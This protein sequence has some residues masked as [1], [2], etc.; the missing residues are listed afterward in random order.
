MKGNDLIELARKKESEKEYDEAINLFKE[1]FEK[2]PKN[3][4]LQIELGNVFALCN[5][6]EEAAG[7]FRRANRRF[8]DNEDIK[9][10]LGFCLSQIG[11]KYH[12]HRNFSMAQ[13]AFEEATF[14]CPQDASHFYNLG[15]AYYAQSNFQMALESFE[16]SSSL[17]S[18][19]DTYHNI[20]NTLKKINDFTNAK[21]NYKLA[22][23]L[24]E[25]Q[26]HTII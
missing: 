19:S 10:G 5:K 3:F 12:A 1:A 2:D 9:V 16:Q 20:G 26:I 22:L 15:N 14:F 8:P 13:A 24:K 4:F 6:F 25:I 23:D 21:I 17:V 7:C 18:D 11:N